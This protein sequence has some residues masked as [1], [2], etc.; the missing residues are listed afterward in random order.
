MKRIIEAARGFLSE[1]TQ[2]G[3]RGK[4]LVVACAVGAMIA[5]A[6]VVSTPNPGLTHTSACHNWGNCNK[7]GKG[8][9]LL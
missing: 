2:I 8:D 6:F 1:T 4:A 3:R 5:G 9:P 7:P